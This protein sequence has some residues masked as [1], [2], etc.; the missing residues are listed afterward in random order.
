MT[1]HPLAIPLA[2]S[3]VVNLVIWLLVAHLHLCHSN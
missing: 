3:L 1:D 2:V